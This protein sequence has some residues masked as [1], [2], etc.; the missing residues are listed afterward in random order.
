MG[1]A[2][3]GSGIQA[4]ELAGTDFLQVPPCAL[5]GSTRLSLVLPMRGVPRDS[6]KTCVVF[7]AFLVLGFVSLCAV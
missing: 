5:G 6:E 2:P 4:R 7:S 3:M 1:T